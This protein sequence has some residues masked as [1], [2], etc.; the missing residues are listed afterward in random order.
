MHPD[1]SGSDDPTLRLLESI[2]PACV[3][4][5]LQA[6]LPTSGI[7]SVGQAAVVVRPVIIAQPSETKRAVLLLIDLFREVAINPVALVS[8]IYFRVKAEVK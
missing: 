4:A 8:I 1:H 3:Q 6:P 7:P 2:Q 5:A